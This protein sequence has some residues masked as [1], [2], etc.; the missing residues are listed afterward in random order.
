MIHLNIV[1]KILFICFLA[2]GRSPCAAQEYDLLLRGGHVIDAKNRIDAVRDVAI[3]DGKIAA[4]RGRRSIR[5]KPAKWSMS[6]LYVTPGLIDIHVHVYAGTGERGSYAGDNSVYPDGFTFRVG[7][8]TVADAGGSGWRNF[9]D[10]R[11][12]AS[13]GRGR[14]CSR[15]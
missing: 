8:T 7:V 12:R 13:T 11:E 3:K 9:E 1:N 5:P 4:V 6:G 10:F 15:S 14:A 2:Y